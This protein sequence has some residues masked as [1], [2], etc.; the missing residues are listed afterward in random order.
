MPRIKVHE[1]VLAHLSRGLYRSPASALRELVSNAW[2]ANALTV[3]INTNYPNFFQ[4]SIKDDGDGFARDDFQN[5]MSGGIGNSEK[6]EEEEKSLINNRQVIGRLG[7][8]MLGI[9]QVCGAFTITSKTDKNTGFRARVTLYD[10][11]KE[12]LDDDDAAIVKDIMV[13]EPGEA[14]SPLKIVDI[15][16]YE[17]EKDFDPNDVEVGTTIITNEIHPTFVQTFKESLDKTKFEKF[18]EP[19]REWKRALQIFSSVHSLQEL[20]DYWRL[21]WE[22]A[23]ACPIPFIS[24]TALPSKLIAEDQRRLESSDFK[25]YVDELQLLKPIA[26]RGNKAGYTTI[27]IE[28]QA[29]R[30][31][32]KDLR[33]HG[34]VVVQE[35][36]QLLP[37]ELRGVLIRIKNVGIGYYDPSLMD[38]RFNEG[39]RAK[40][41]TA[42]IY[43]DEGLEDALNI[44]RD[45]FN[46]FHPEFRILQ[47]Y[48]HDLL[49][50]QVFPE[51]YKKIGLRS[52]AK[53]S[54]KEEE[55]TE[56][57]QA[58]SSALVDGPVKI[59]H[60]SVEP[61]HLPEAKLVEKAKHLELVLPDPDDLKTKKPYRQ[62]ASS[63]LA[64]YE[65]SLREKNREK[66]R[67]VFTELVLKLLMGW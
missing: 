28:P 57:L 53:A 52:K 47:S 35:G 38:Y 37:D 13:Q 25:V 46:R 67:K 34:Y 26:L 15:G 11:L 61:G 49:H 64:I 4:L 20:G 39:P 66:Q 30:V 40:W 1:K 29:R 31:Y 36:K 21:L 41:V 8:G 63:L 16:K 50:N 5:L 9:A 65:I 44:D 33:F 43:V 32:S 12:R 48:F 58:I 17:F 24:E 18:K 56:H 23:A 19:P 59:T 22:L 2:D 45:S 62:L 7:I 54:A 6:R 27:R 3:R 10:L 42:E 60:E 55:H 51:V 14:T